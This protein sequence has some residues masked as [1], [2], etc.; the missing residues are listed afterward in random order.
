VLA[1]R[2]LAIGDGMP[3]DIKGA[4]AQ[5]LDTLFIADGIHG[6]E[7][8]PYTETHLTELLAKNG[9]TAAAALRSLKW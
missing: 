4:N 2:P 8:E 5:G 3:T 6:E 1:K 9:L 7:I